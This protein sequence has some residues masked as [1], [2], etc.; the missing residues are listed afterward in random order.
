MVEGKATRDPYKIS[1][2]EKVWLVKLEFAH[3][4]VSLPTMLGY[5][6]DKALSIIQ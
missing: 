4:G 6:L 3:G 2:N 1:A 5:P